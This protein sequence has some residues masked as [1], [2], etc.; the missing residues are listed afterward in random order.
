VNLAFRVLEVE[1][2]L[3]II[4]HATND[5]N[6]RGGAHPDCYQRPS[7]YLGLTPRG[8]VWKQNLED[9]G[10]SALYRF[11]A[12][13]LGWMDDPTNLESQFESIPC[14]TDERPDPAEALAAN[15]P[16]YFERNLRSM[17]G[18]AQA[19]GVQPVL[20]SWTYLRDSNLDERPEWW[21][22]GVDEHNAIIERLAGEYDIPFYD[23]AANFPLEPDWWV[24]GGIHM[25]PAGTHEQARQ[26]A[27]FLVDAGL[28]PDVEN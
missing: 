22:Q 9:P 28:L 20:S 11:V 18:I 27:A 26:Y 1:P 5:V 13:N 24:S 10:P 25:E 16:T 15:P 3:I 4:F 8:G 21:R 19:N 23:L 14:P 7:P 6:I 17:I 2:D 12:I